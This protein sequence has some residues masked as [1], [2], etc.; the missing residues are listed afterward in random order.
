[1]EEHLT[2]YDFEI[3]IDADLK[4]DKDMLDHECLDQPR[5]FL[6]WSIHMSNAIKQRDWAKRTVLITRSDKSVD[7]RQNPGK[8]GL[9][10]PTEGSVAATLETLPEIS[11]V[12]NILIE[13]QRTVNIF[14]AAKEAFDQRKKM[15]ELLVQLYL[16]GYYSRP[17]QDNEVVTK[18]VEAGTETLK[19]NLRLRMK[20]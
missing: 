18:T 9:E 5:R 14:S 7:V 6:K 4:I 10:K 8:Y 15:L 11:D 16:S 17:K 19:E 20:K 13:N 1:M 12:E 3:E 2:V